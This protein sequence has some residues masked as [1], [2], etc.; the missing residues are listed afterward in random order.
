[1]IERQRCSFSQEWLSAVAE[2]YSVGGLSDEKSPG[3]TDLF[4]FGK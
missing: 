4:D 3:S 2:S 1:M